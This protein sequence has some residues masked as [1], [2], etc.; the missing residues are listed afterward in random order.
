MKGSDVDCL[1]DIA[2]HAESI[3]ATELERKKQ[4]RRCF[5]S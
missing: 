2:E 4:S 3:S 1:Q 5:L